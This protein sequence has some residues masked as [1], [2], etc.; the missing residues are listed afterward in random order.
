MKKYL[1]IK[2]NDFE[3]ARNEI[4]NRDGKKEI[5][6]SSDDDELNRKVLEK[7]KIRFLLINLSGRKDGPK[8]RNSGFNGVMAKIAKKKNV[9][10]GINLNEIMESEG[11]EK[12]E[13]LARIRQNVKLCNRNDL[14]MK[15]ISPDEKYEKN[16]R[17][18]KSLGLVLGMPTGIVKDL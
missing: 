13:I 18:L 6:F 12:A 16:V 5:I 15:F 11:K 9:G 4:R 17:D 10:M 8:Q 2:E 3:R 7:E 14:K 1:L